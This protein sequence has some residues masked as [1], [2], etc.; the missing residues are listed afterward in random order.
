MS[1]VDVDFAGE[2][3]Q[4]VDRDGEDHRRGVYVCILD[5]YTRT[6]PRRSGIKYSRKTK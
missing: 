6:I 3:R 5:E 2:R 4:T 1:C